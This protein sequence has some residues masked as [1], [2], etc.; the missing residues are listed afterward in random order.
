MLSE[1]LDNRR[2]PIEQHLFF[3]QHLRGRR[4]AGLRFVNLNGARHLLTQPLQPFNTFRY[5]DL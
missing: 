1:V 3:V 2:P 5:G 4:F